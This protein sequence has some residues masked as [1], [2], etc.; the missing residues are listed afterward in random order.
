MPE[1]AEIEERRGRWHFVSRLRWRSP[2]GGTGTW[3][4]RVARRRGYVETAVDGVVSR[5][6][7]RPATT[8]RLI[9]CNAVSATA[10]VLGG[11]LFT[12][13]GLLAQ[14][15]SA[16]ATTIDLV[17]LIGGVFFSL[18][19][20][21]SI[22]QALNAPRAVVDGELVA[23]GWRWWGYEPMRPGWVSAFVLFVGTLAFFVS[24]ARAFLSNLTVGQE[25]RLLWAPEMLGCILF[26]VSGHVAIAEA[27]HGRFRWQPRSLGWWVVAVNQLGSI[28]FLISG[29]AGFVRHTTGDAINDTIVNWGTALGA[30][31]FSVAGVLQLFE[32][33]Q[34]PE[35]LTAST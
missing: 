31:C 34:A 27:C 26:L 32:R 15:S 8:V 29:L 18:G 6:R 5:L 13:G 22:V 24:L 11:A 35:R 12:A 21:V 30:A 16:S 19:G 28:L 33:P 9:R 1:D 23:D 25:D 14:L 3:E 10:F 4:S 7:A 2:D 20:Y 17:F